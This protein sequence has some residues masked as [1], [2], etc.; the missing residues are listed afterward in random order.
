M[1]PPMSPADDTDGL[2]GGPL[3]GIRV[4]EF[5]Q[6]IAGPVA[7][8]HL[9]DLGAD[10]VKVEP[11][12]GEDR[13]NSGA[14]VPNEGKY[15]QSLN[16]GKRSVTIDLGQAAGRDLVKRLLPHFDVVL[17]N[18]R[19]GVAERLGIDY[20]SLRALRPDIIC[21]TITGFGDRGPY[22]TRAGSDI[23]TQAY[24]GMIAAEG[25][26]DEEGA[27]VWLTATPFIDRS[28]A[29]A[30]AMAICA[31][32]FERSRT[33]RGQ[34][35]RLS[36]LQT[37][38]E[39]MSN[40]VMREPVHDVTVRDPLLERMQAARASGVAFRDV[41]GLRDETVRLT[42]HRLYYRGYD[43]KQGALILGAITLQNRNTIRRVLG[44]H[45]DTDS[46]E[47]DA[48]A[49]DAD[50]RVEGWRAEIQAKLMARSAEEWEAVFVQEGVPASTVHLAEEMSDDV[51][52]LAEGMM[53]P[54]VHPVTGPQRV[55][56][57]L[58]RM[59]AT[60][61]VAAR[62]APTLGQHTD[63]V[64]RECGLTDDEVAA[65]VEAGVVTRWE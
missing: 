41:I 24:S 64:L 6:I 38:L 49:P 36:L 39:L 42:S 54:L 4:L 26:V 43:T 47:F 1:P 32:L 27:P 46:P 51:Q 37:A 35:V 60:P 30:A 44:I 52:V 48:A 59:S 14:V 58:V 31:A 15:F 3:R 65:L 50:A 61:V 57:P 9:S 40:K 28:T 17:S 34:E 2:G 18:Y 8:I 10:V 25:K 55:V 56:S 62:P 12:R 53:T 23:A 45:D 7:G 20:E 29:F 13:R 33:G 11:P 16:R 5:T 19:F 21:A 63:E 22:A